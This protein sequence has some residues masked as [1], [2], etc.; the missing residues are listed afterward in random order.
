MFT[1]QVG[2]VEEKKVLI[3]SIA[4]KCLSLLSW[5]SWCCS[6]PQW[7]FPRLYHPFNFILRWRRWSCCTNTFWFEEVIIIDPV[8]RNQSLFCF[9]VVINLPLFWSAAPGTGFHTSKI[10]VISLKQSS[11]F[12]LLKLIYFSFKK[13]IQYMN[14]AGIKWNDD[15]FNRPAGASRVNWCSKLK[16]LQLKR[17]QSTDGFNISVITDISLSWVLNTFTCTWRLVY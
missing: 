15:V 16:F 2:R 9:D 14:T 11:L 17:D 8:M 10:W 3:W 1:R 6:A 13:K 12:F 7:P 4:N 5:P